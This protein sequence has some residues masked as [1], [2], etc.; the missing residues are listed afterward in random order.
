MNKVG[1]LREREYL[2]VLLIPFDIG[3]K[4]ERFRNQHKF[5]KKRAGK[6]LRQEAL[7]EKITDKINLAIKLI[8]RFMKRTNRG[9]G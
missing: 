8:N 6:P 9:A 7:S 2:F 1:C 5:E 3:G 4:N